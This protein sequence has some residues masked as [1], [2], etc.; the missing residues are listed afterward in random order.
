MKILKGKYSDEYYDLN[1]ELEDEVRNNP[2]IFHVSWLHYIMGN[3]VWDENCNSKLA[4]NFENVFYLSLLINLINGIKYFL[5]PEVD[6]KLEK[7]YVYYSEFEYMSYILFVNNLEKDGYI[8]FF[9][10]CE[11]LPNNGNGKIGFNPNAPY[12]GHKD[13]I[14]YIIEKQ[15]EYS[16]ID[17]LAY[18]QYLIKHSPEE[19]LKMLLPCFEE[20]I[21]DIP[22]G[23]VIWQTP[24]LKETMS[25]FEKLKA[26]E[27]ER[28]W[29]D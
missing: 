28:G 23:S 12:L 2:N 24:L 9:M 29:V 17:G 5:L 13:V 18:N 1:E 22:E 27:K 10:G 15:N 26:Y 16:K 7:N 8:Y 20:N 6:K 4:F 11:D 21:Y 25:N 19:F 14:E 3:I